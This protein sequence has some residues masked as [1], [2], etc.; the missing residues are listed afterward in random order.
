QRLPAQVRQ[1]LAR[2]VG[3]E[4]EVSELERERMIA[5]IQKALSATDEGLLLPPAEE[6]EGRSPLLRRKHLHPFA[7]GLPVPG[8]L[9]VDPCNQLVARHEEREDRLRVGAQR[10][11]E[12]IL[13][14]YL[15]QRVSLPDP[16]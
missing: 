4:P 10:A 3:A 14:E 5:S 9:L 15:H 11:R 6:I 16:L 2:R 7:V 8:A 1:G 12:E 13:V